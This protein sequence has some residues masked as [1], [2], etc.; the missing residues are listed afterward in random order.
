MTVGGRGSRRRWLRRRWLPVTAG[1]SERQKSQA[2]CD[3][4]DGGGSPEHDGI[5]SWR[6]A[7]RSSP[8]AAQ[9]QAEAV[10]QDLRP[11]DPEL[12]AASRAPK[13]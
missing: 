8:F 6:L 11:L 5:L 13:V 1:E 10:I 2:A 7:A 12:R 9:A 4:S 3:A